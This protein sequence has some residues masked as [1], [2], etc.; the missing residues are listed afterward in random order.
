MFIKSGKSMSVFLLLPSLIRFVTVL[1][2]SPFIAFQVLSQDFK[3][4][5]IFSSCSKTS[6]HKEFLNSMMSVKVFTRI[7]SDNP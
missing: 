1:M 6:S 4:L 2:E 5:V 3:L 7:I